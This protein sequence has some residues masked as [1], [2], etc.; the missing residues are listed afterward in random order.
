LHI[1]IVTPSLNRRGGTEKCL[2]WLVEDLSQSCDVT[3]FTGEVTDTDISRCQVHRLP[4]IPHPRLLRYLSFLLANTIAL[5][6]Y[7]L[8]RKRPFDLVLATGGDCVFSNVVYAHF[9]C[10]AWA[11]IIRKGE[12]ALPSSGIRRHLRNIHYALFLWVASQAEH[13]IYHLP[14]VKATVAV[15]S[16]TKAEITHHYGVSPERV[17]V[18]PNAADERVRL[19]I[20]EGQQHRNA[21][22]A[23][24]GISDTARVLLFVGAGD[25]KRKGLSLALRALAILGDP[26][27]HL[28]VVGSE[29]I[30]FYRNE[31]RRLG[32]QEYVHFCGFTAQIERYYAAADIFVYPSHYETFSLVTFEAAA[33]GLPLIVTRT[34]G[35]EELVRDGE[36]GFFVQPDADDISAKLRH[37][38]RDTVLQ[39][40]MSAAARVSSL[41]YTRS[42]VL[43]RMLALFISLRSADRENVEG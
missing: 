7:R 3:V 25:W 5:V 30:G 34:S 31:A 1:A 13:V 12:V 26:S 43:G 14:S 6:R 39:Q 22:R 41:S 15:S 21:I 11:S 10:A 23:T 24:L 20:S 16:G 37:V 18:V 27:V 40:R 4:M 29:D 17:W 36:N 2:A 33:A 38:L 8:L 28:I 35:S 9:C 19:S 42:A 32:R